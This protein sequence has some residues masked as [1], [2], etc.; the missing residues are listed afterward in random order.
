MFRHEQVVQNESIARHMKRFF[1]TLPSERQRDPETVARSYGEFLW[2][3]VDQRLVLQEKLPGSRLYVSLPMRDSGYGFADLT[4]RAVLISDTLLLSHHKTGNY[5]DITESYNPDLPRLAPLPMSTGQIVVSR[6]GFEEMWREQEETWREQAGRGRDHLAEMCVMD[7]PSLGE[8]GRWI[9]D[10]ESLLAAGLV[11]YLPNY[12]IATYGIT[13]GVRAPF[14]KDTV[15]PV[16]VI[17]YLAR[18]ARAVD[19]FGAEP[20]K[21][22][23]VRPVLRINLPFVEGV[24][25]RD[26]GRITVGEFAS[27]S[28]F[29]GFLR[30]SFLGMD[31]A[32]NAVQSDRELRKL[33]L[34]IEDQVRSV[35]SK[36]ETA[37][38]KRAVAV[39][40]AV[41]GSVGAILVAVYGPELAK[42]VAAIGAS[43]GVWGIIHAVSENSTWDLRQDKWYYVW[44][45]A[46]K[47]K[48]H[49]L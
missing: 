25:L 19:A 42:A 15:R 44:A 31:A 18:D 4:K 48:I 49:V 24:N 20:V 5:H 9:L 30:Q 36:M 38:R 34:Q 17:D 37:R 29:R 23:L 46:K 12:A 6:I 47:G 32:V 10:A 26:F 3:S 35:R 2:Y 40:G 39:T 7:C 8:L 22:Q 13:D 11:W 33:G 21:S 41:I 28:A 16:T 1:G 14:D 27:Y 45:L 43:G